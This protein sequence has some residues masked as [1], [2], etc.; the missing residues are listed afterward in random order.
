MPT[1]AKQAAGVA[2]VT[3][4][5]VPAGT[6]GAGGATGAA[7]TASDGAVVTVVVTGGG[8]TG[9]TIVG[10]ML[11][12]PLADTARLIMDANEEAFA[13]LGS[14]TTALVKFV[15]EAPKEV[16]EAG[17]TLALT[18]AL[19]VAAEVVNKL[20]DAGKEP[21]FAAASLDNEVALEIKEPVE[22]MAKDARNA[23]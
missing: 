5:V 22:L 17:A 13:N 6:V 1:A 14:G 8:A 23:P 9:I 20:A 7:G 21:L 15:K 12:P 16:K 11:T 3:V 2:V 4:A 18:I 19:K 10:G